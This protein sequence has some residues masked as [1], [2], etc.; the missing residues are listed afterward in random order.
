MKFKKIAK[1]FLSCMMAGAL[2]TG[3]G[4]GGD[5]PAAE[6]P[7]AEKPAGESGDIKLGMISHLNATE[8]RME[9]ILQM[10]QEDSGVQIT[11]YKITYYD[12][13][14]LMQMGI[15]SGSIDQISVYKSVAKY[16]MAN[17]D[18][19]ENIPEITLKTLDDNFCFAVRKEDAALKADL[20]KALDEM[21]ADGS[22]EKLATE[23]IVN[24]D[25][26][27]VPP[28]IEIPMTDGA[29]T[30]KVGVTGDLPPLDYVS[31][32]GQAAGFNTALLAEIAKRSGKNI[33]IVDIDS[34][35]RATALSSKQIDVI[36][37]VV[38]PTLDKVPADMDKPEGVELS[39]PYF[40]DSIEHL[41]LKK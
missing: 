38:V 28:A 31:A 18:K 36:F 40:R 12:S 10:V 11:K 30:I 13:L 22:L 37:W 29:D 39:N 7:A 6:K 14:K 33:E 20:N 3:C 2:F 24:V 8:Q 32:D 34:G 16:L 26:G 1:V 35:A 9:E 23:Y 41:K 5:K 27:K 17:N 25:K 15:E 21:K 4:G 19:Y